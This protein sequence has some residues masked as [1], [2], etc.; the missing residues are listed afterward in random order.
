MFPEWKRLLFIFVQVLC[1]Y[2]LRGIFPPKCIYLIQC[3][4]SFSVCFVR[5]RCFCLLLILFLYVLMASAST[6]KSSK[7][8]PSPVHLPG[9]AYGIYNSKSTERLSKKKNDNMYAST[10]VLWDLMRWSYFSGF[11]SLIV[12]SR[13]IFMPLFCVCASA[14]IHFYTHYSSTIS[15]WY[16]IFIEWSSET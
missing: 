9:L 3:W 5:S 12:Y 7:N 15:L 13:W 6:A 14:S 1:V 16:A 4:H 8:L 2:V 10:F 11:N